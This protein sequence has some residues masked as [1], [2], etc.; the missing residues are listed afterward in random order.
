MNPMPGE[1]AAI[2]LKS[3]GVDIV[4]GAGES[5][6]PWPE[7]CRAGAETMVYNNTHRPVRKKK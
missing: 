5:R 6:D 4:A 7:F 1:P 2:K 3:P